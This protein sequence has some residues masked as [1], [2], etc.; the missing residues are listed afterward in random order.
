MRPFRS[1]P[2]KIGRYLAVLCLLA[3]AFT[4]LAVQA[5][6]QLAA[7]HNPGSHAEAGLH[8]AGHHGA[9]HHG[10]GDHV[11]R[12]ASST[13]SDEGQVD[14]DPHQHD[15]YGPNADAAMFRVPGRSCSLPLLAS[16]AGV[17]DATA[18]RIRTRDG[19]A[20]GVGPPALQAP[21]TLLHCSLLI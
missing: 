6:L 15:G 8:V 16:S 12:P 18:V 10:T 7:H 2:H 13:P 5:H 20:E 11:H 3:P 4:A 9:G 19:A 1:A 14:H 17:D 21:L